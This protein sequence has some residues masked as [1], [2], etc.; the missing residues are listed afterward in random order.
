M[1]FGAFATYTHNLKHST[2]YQVEEHINEFT[3]W[4]ENEGATVGNIEIVLDSSCDT[5]KV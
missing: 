3:Q 4:L 5:F 2:C 1:L